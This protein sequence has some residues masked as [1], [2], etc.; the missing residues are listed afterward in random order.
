MAGK[1][2]LTVQGPFETTDVRVLD[3]GLREVAAGTHSLKA[4]LDPGIYRVVAQVPGSSQEKLVV[5]EAGKPVSVGDFRLAWDSV[6]PHGQSRSRHEYQ[7]DP[8]VRVSHQTH[9]NLGG[10]A[11]LLVYVRTPGK[12][13]AGVPSF[14]IL[15]AKGE[16]S[17]AFPEVGEH[18]GDAGWAACSLT[19]PA[20]TYQIEHSTPLGLRAQTIFADDNWQT[21]MF[22]PWSDTVD[23]GS[24]VLHMRRPAQGFEPANFRQYTKTEAALDGLAD[25][26]LVLNPADIDDFLN[27]KFEDPMLGLIGAYALLLQNEVDYGRLGVISDNLLNLIPH[28]PDARLLHFIAASSGVAPAAAPPGGWPV[29]TEPPLFAF[30]CERLLDFA[31][32]IKDVCPAASWLGR[33]SMSLSTGSTWTRWDPALDASE[34]MTK[35]KREINARISDSER[36]LEALARSFA[37]GLAVASFKLFKP[38]ATVPLL[39]KFMKGIGPPLLQW[40]EDNG[41]F[42]IDAV[43]ER[44]ANSMAVKLAPE[45]QLPQSVTAEAL[46]KLLDEA[47]PVR[48]RPKK[49][50]QA[51]SNALVPP[52]VISPVPVVAKAPKKKAAVR[53]RRATKTVAHR[54]TAKV[55]AGRKGVSKAAAKKRSRKK[56]KKI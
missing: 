50:L 25:H 1:G 23:F 6:A 8:A 13:G 43:N 46:K 29:F 7:T 45:L 44:T 49:T 36:A 3:A 26:R 20:G 15:N 19:L 39:M 42:D 11:R 28:S 27:G 51:S 22:V 48:K 9:A 32:R 18:N 17:A 38:A 34:A 31:S 40:L 14:R 2:T 4:E 16:T 56:L 55:S 37:D 30:G 10:N 33:I 52:T 35:L 41:V 53:R 21:Q 5:V 12:P 47:I 24:A 54:R